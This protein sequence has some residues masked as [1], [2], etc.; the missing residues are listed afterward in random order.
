MGYCAGMVTIHR[1]GRLRIVIY[2]NDHAPAHVHAI[3]PDGHCRINLESVGAPELISV[4][5]MRAKDVREAQR[6]VANNLDAF[7][8]EWRRIHG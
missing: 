3:N 1:A 8:A 5:G 7:L 6:L 2:S 4:D